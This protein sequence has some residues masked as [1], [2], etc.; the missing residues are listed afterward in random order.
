MTSHHTSSSSFSE[1]R[2]K[3][4]LHGLLYFGPPPEPGGSDRTVILKKKQSFLPLNDNRNKAAGEVVEEQEKEEAPKINTP[5]TFTIPCTSAAGYT[6]IPVGFQKFDDNDEI[7][8]PISA[9]KKP[10]PTNKSASRERKK[11]APN[12]S[13]EEHFQDLMQ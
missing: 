8:A 1:P 5:A 6:T 3:V 9:K 2:K 12:K 11:R 10:E 7:H 4:V 13:F